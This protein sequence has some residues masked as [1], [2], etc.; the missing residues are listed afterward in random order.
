MEPTGTT[1]ALAATA[2]FLG[3]WVGERALLW[4]RPGAYFALCAPLGGELASMPEAPPESG[5]TKSVLWERRGDRVLFW[6]D[7]RTRTVPGGLHGVVDL[8][9]TDGSV[10]LTARWAPP[11]TPLVAA[12]WLAGIGIARGEWFTIPV[13]LLLVL[14]IS[15]LYRQAARTVVAELRAAWVAA[16]S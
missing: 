1:V 12:L 8:T 5:E 6:A 9:P 14:S 16:R 2:A 11:I 15:V 13:A 10:G 4:W 7:G 3:S